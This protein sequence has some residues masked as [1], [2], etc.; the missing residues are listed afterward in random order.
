ML[1][2]NDIF[3]WDG[4]GG[5]LKLVSGKCKLRIIDRSQSDGQAMTFVRP[6]V[7]VVS[8]IEGETVSVKSCAGH[9][10]TLVTEKFNINHT[11]FKS[12]YHIWSENLFII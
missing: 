11:S 3:Y 7:I 8:D 2:Y 9:I 4:F 6:I 1:I 10:A 5:K 12:R